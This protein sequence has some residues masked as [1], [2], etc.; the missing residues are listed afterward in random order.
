VIK[1]VESELEWA[2]TQWLNLY[3]GVGLLDGKYKQPQPAN[4]AKKLQRT[5]EFQGKA[6]FAATLPVKKGSIVATGNVY[7]VS[8][9]MLTP[10]NLSF[11]APLLANK[12]LDVSG[13]YAVVDA[14]LSYKLNDGSLSLQCTNCFDKRY[15]EGT[16]YLGAFAGAWVG[17]PRMVKL[18]ITESF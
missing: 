12:G 11:T 18:S 16:A 2:P 10:A 1:G 17:Q 5:P 6:G 13:K 7:Y 4:L 3:A 14:S 9:Y 8:E 15:V